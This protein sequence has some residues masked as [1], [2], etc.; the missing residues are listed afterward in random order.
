[1]ITVKSKKK[2]KWAHPNDNISYRCRMLFCQG[3]VAEK[4]QKFFSRYFFNTASWTPRQR[5]NVYFSKRILD[6]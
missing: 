6:S 1:M 2:V 5:T 3:N 4:F